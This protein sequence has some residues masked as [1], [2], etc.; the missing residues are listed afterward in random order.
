VVFWPKHHLFRALIFGIGS[1]L[2]AALVVLS[3]WGYESE[4]AFGLDWL[5][6]LR[7]PQTAPEDVVIVA[8]N[9]AA[10]EA[11]GAEY[12]DITSWS[13]ELHARLLDG[14][15]QAGARVVAFDLLFRQPKGAEDEAF[16]AAMR[17]SGNVA[18]LEFLDRNHPGMVTYADQQVPVTLQERLVPAPRLAAAAAASGPFTLPRVPDRVS[19]FWVFDQNAGGAASL[20]LVALLLYVSPDYAAVRERINPGAAAQMGDGPPSLFDLL[21]SKSPAEVANLLSELVTR[22]SSVSG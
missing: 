5:F 15:R 21:S 18:L 20:P 1:G 7:G 16:A 8:I 17:S 9:K 14:L 11:L 10:S 3:P 12:A 13:R 4:E 2:A 22:E 19:R 6:Q